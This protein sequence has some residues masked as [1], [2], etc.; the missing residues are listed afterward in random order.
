MFPYMA[1]MWIFGIRVTVVFLCRVTGREIQRELRWML[2]KS[3]G[4]E[5][6]LRDDGSITPPAKDVLFA[7]FYMHPE[8]SPEKCLQ[9][10]LQSNWMDAKNLVDT[11]NHTYLKFMHINPER[12]PFS[13]DLLKL[14]EYVR[15]TCGMNCDMEHPQVFLL[16][17]IYCCDTINMTYRCRVANVS[18]YT[19]RERT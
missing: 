12:I 8:I 18:I 3:V 9:E 2:Q 16:L 19:E 13:I 7:C 14:E 15:K 4:N 10:L 1:V 5:F 11:I 6:F 17:K